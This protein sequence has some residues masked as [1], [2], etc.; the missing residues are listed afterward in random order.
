[1]TF[2]LYNEHTD[3]PIKK[4]DGTNYTLKLGEHNIWSQVF[5]VGTS[6]LDIDENDDNVTGS[7]GTFG[8][9]DVYVVE[10]ALNNSGESY[11]V[12]HPTT[13]DVETENCSDEYLYGERAAGE[14]IFEVTTNHHRYQVLYKEKTTETA[15]LSVAAAFAVTNRRLGNIDATVEKVW[16]DGQTNQPPT[17]PL[18]NDENLSQQ[19]GTELQE[20]Q[21]EKGKNLALVFRL[22]FAQTPSEDWKITHSGPNTTCLLYTSNW[23]SAQIRLICLWVKNKKTAKVGS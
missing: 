8:A 5:F 9:E 10:T 21:R 3:Q 17:M 1:M 4:K 20:I 2:T 19:I 6:E 14:P 7:D 23:T 22:Q 16:V 18:V 11:K 12:K 13:A 15:G